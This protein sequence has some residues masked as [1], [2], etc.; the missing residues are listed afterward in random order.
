MVKEAEANKETDKKK[1]ES[2]EVRNQADT[3]TIPFASI[4]KVTSICG[5]PLGAGAIPT[6]SKF[7]KILLSDA[8]SLSPC[9]TLL[10]TAG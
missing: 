8:I 9:K 2:V 5:T 10:D 1:R 3:L 6:N 7:P 4:S